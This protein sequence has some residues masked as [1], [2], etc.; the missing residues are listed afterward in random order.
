LRYRFL[1]LNPVLLIVAV[2]PGEEARA[3]RVYRQ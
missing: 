3:R 1:L 2:L